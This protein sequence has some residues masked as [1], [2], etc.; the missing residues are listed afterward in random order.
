VTAARTD[1][2][3]PRFWWCRQRLAVLL[4]NLNTPAATAGL[5]NVLEPENWTRLCNV[6]DRLPFKLL[7][8]ELTLNELV[9]FSWWRKLYSF[10]SANWRTRWGPQHWTR[11]YGAPTF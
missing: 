8:E 11:C 7:L 3:G 1:E 4:A 10:V 6:G 9:T 2:F 5:L